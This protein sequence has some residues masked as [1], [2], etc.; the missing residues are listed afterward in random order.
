M[1]RLRKAAKA[2]VFVQVFNWVGL[3][4]SLITVPLYLHWL[5]QERYGLLLTGLAFAGY[6]MFSDAGL[7]WASMLL[8]AQANGREDRN[9]IGAIVRTSF[10]L[11]ACSALLVLIIVVS[12][13]YLMTRTHALAWLPQNAEFP[14]LMLVV[15]T[16]VVCNLGI[17]PFYNLFIG[18]QEAHLAA[19]YQGIGRILGTLAAVGI[20][21]SGASLGWVFAG[22]V[23][24]SLTAGL[25][26]GFHCR[27][28]HGWAFQPGSRW[29]WPQVRQQLRT[30]AKSLTMQMGNVLW[31]TAPILAIS[32]VAGAQFVPLYSIPMTLLNAPLGF[33]LSFSASLQPGYGE[34][35][36]RGERQW[37]ADTVRRILRQVLLLLGLLTCGFWFLATPFVRLWTGGK[38]ELQPTILTSVLIVACTGVILGVFR[39]A[40]SGINRHRM[41]ALSD[42]IG[43][44]LAIVFALVAVKHFG[45]AAV[46]LGM[47]LAVVLTSAWVLP[48]E[49]RRALMVPSLS[50]KPSFW[51]R[52]ILVVAASG[53]VGWASVYELSGFS[54]LVMVLVCGV[55]ISALFFLLSWKLLP[56]ETGIIN[57]LKKILPHQR[58]PPAS[59]MP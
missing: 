18:L 5:G 56:E 11:A 55:A 43:G 30:G 38:I 35:M 15:G 58:K 39:F 37:V 6:L 27:C 54:S 7:N 25:L 22:N 41:A 3:L 1:S 10:S 49:L 29:E 57:R 14:G 4:L 33:A 24:G 45:Y 32:T 28:R 8:I 26:A 9:A 21:W 48:R 12:A 46:G 42:L 16:S 31:G 40:L 53:A 59:V 50:P 52:W 2:A 19:L 47:G 34:A 20:A 13:Y 36:G 51:L 17:S 44:A 23:A